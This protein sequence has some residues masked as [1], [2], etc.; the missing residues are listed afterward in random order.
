MHCTHSFQLEIL[1][2]ETSPFTDVDLCRKWPTRSQIW[3]LQF[4]PWISHSDLKSSKCERQSAGHTLPIELPRVVAQNVLSH[5]WAP[6]RQNGNTCCSICFWCS[7]L[8]C[9]VLLH[10]NSSGSSPEKTIQ[11]GYLANMENR[12]CSFAM[13]NVSFLT[14]LQITHSSYTALWQNVI[15]Q[16]RVALG[17]GTSLSPHIGGIEILRNYRHHPPF[18]YIIWSPSPYAP[19]DSVH[20]NGSNCHREH[21][22]LGLHRHHR[23]AGGS[24]LG[25]RSHIDLGAGSDDGWPYRVEQHE[26]RMPLFGYSLAGVLGDFGLGHLFGHEDCAA[27]SKLN[28]K[29]SAILR[30]G[31]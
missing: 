3:I 6:S 11:T 5:R 31:C 16:Y 2:C 8:L 1:I 25:P 19:R 14:R 27:S 28:G 9:S 30:F 7:T 21:I 23:G 26:D 10:R 20:K 15:T 18:L 12:L 29:G 24:R 22:S 4:S 17:P 13:G